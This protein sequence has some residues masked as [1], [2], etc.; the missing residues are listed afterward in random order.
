MKHGSLWDAYPCVS[1]GEGGRRLAE[2]RVLTRH[3]LTSDFP[4]EHCV[5]SLLVRIFLLGQLDEGILDVPMTRTEGHVDHV[6]ILCH[7][8]QLHLGE[9]LEFGLSR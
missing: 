8:L 5:S 9:D 3:Q 6:S 4:P 1:S 2:F 7:V